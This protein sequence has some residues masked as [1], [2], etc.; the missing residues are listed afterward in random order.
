MTPTDQTSQALPYL[1]QEWVKPGTHLVSVPPSNGPK[2]LWRSII[3]S[4]LCRLQSHWVHLTIRMS[5][6]FNCLDAVSTVCLAKPKSPSFSWAPGSLEA[7]RRFSGFRSLLVWY[8]VMIVFNVKRPSKFP[9]F[10]L[11]LVC[12]FV[13]Y[14]SYGFW[15]PVC[16]VHV[17][18]M[19]NCQAYFLHDQRRFLFSE[20]IL[21]GICYLNV[22]S[23]QTKIFLKIWT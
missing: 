20:S 17:M 22:R 2:H 14:I 19:F 3:G 1:I 6:N 15:W 7:Y 16:N 13:L 10:V 18:K 4:V 8:Q 12:L 23:Y 11:S 5:T 9:F 21:L